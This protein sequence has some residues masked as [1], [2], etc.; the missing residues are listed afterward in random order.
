MYNDNLNIFSALRHPQAN[1][2]QPK[3]HKISFARKKY[4]WLN[5]E[6][7]II[8]KNGISRSSLSP[9]SLH[10]IRQIQKHKCKLYKRSKKVINDHDRE[11]DDAVNVY[12]I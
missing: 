11:G 12:R 6:N 8:S 7:E 9:S 2:E 3:P 5:L 1:D 10:T 4:F